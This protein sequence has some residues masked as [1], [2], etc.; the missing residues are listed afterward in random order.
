VSQEK[1]IPSE[2]NSAKHASDAIFWS[3][4]RSV[5]VTGL[6]AIACFII[7][8]WTLVGDGML[9]LS[10]YLVFVAFLLVSA[11]G[12]VWRILKLAPSRGAT[13][14]SRGRAKVR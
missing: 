8:F 2:S 1:N 11:G 3:S 6:G 7:S 13:S 14:G 9:T 5:E 4:E 10:Q 12:L